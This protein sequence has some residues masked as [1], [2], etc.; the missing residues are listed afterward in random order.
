MNELVVVGQPDELIKNEPSI[1]SVVDLFVKS[2]LAENT[3]LAYSKDV[4]QFLQ[5]CK[6]SSFRI[7]HLCDFQSQHLAQYR[8]FLLHTAKLEANSVL[9]KLV[10]ARALMRW[11]CNEG[12]IERNPFLNVQL[13]RA[14]QISSTQDFTDLEVQKILSLPPSWLPSGSLHHLVLILLFYIGLRKR[15]LVN[16]KLKDMYDQGAHRV[17]R[18]NGKGSKFRQVPLTPII[19]GAIDR[20]MGISGKTFTPEDYLLKPIRNNRSG[21]IEKQLHVSSID[22]IV[23]H[24]TAKARIKKRVSPHSCRAT[25]VGHLLD[26]KIPIRDIANLLGHSNIQTTAIYD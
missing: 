6:D 15:E 24:Y 10:A 22:W 18:I 4:R 7:Y 25:V 16:I 20:Y 13:P 26:Q 8:D 9:R 21:I 11:S 17:L 1:E 3:K 23:S 14:K 19:Q 5:Y 12:I 2:Y